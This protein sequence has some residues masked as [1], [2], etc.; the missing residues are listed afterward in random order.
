LDIAQRNPGVEGGGD[1][2][3]PQSVRPDQLGDPAPAG[4][5]AD[6]P[7][8]A[9]PVQPLPVRAAEDRSFH[10]LADGQV[11]RPRGARR[12]RGPG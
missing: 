12:E 3:V 11:D 7:G 5:S 8:G 2:R 6:D 4:D 10:A 1:E 9:V